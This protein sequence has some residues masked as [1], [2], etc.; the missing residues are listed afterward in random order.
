MKEEVRLKFTAEQRSNS[1]KINK[2]NKDGIKC[3]IVLCLH[4]L[5]VNATKIN[6][7]ILNC[8]ASNG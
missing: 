8:R 5:T 1:D 7:F 3:S 2:L 4:I 6:D